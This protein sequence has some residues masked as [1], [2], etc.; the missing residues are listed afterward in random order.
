MP[1]MDGP[2]AAQIICELYRTQKVEKPFIVCLTAFTEKIFEEKARQAGIDEFISKPIN[3]AKLKKMMRECHL[4]T[5][6]ESN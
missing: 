6:A 4:I 2:T 5:Q 1:K 3:N